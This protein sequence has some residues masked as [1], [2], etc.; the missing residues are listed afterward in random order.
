MKLFTKSLAPDTELGVAE[1][2]SF[3]SGNWGIKIVS[4]IIS[5]FLM[6]FY[7]DVMN[8]DF[9]IIGMIMLFS[10]VYLFNYG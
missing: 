6:F 8:L 3:M 1:R 7:T 9:A 4:G 2:F 5:T 10:R